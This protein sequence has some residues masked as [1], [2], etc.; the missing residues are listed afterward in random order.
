MN[1]EETKKTNM[2]AE[3][4]PA[5]P[6]RPLLFVKSGQGEFDSH[7]LPPEK[8][9]ILISYISIGLLKTFRKPSVKHELEHCEMPCIMPFVIR[10]SRSHRH[11][12]RQKA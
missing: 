12:A 2:K 5:R 4:S 9:L 10:V 8:L 1:Q 6:S 7:T 3:S 11:H